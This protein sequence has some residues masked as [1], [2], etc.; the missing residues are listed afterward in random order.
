MLKEKRTCGF[1]G[2]DGCVTSQKLTSQ[3][4]NKKYY[5]LQSQ[6]RYF[7]P[8]KGIPTKAIKK[9]HVRTK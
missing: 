5:S 4:G 2:G 1:Y 7:Y 6:C 9:V 3:N 8:Y